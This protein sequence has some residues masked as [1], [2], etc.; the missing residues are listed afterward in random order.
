MFP[1]Y[2]CVE[3]RK[4]LRG[5]G[6]RGGLHPIL[7][8]QCSQATQHLTGGVLVPQPL[9]ADGY[10]IRVKVCIMRLKIAFLFMLTW[11]S[12]CD[13]D[14]VHPDITALVDWVVKYQFTYLPIRDA[15]EQTCWVLFSWT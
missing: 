4:E 8:L 12:N 13:H 11:V 5:G 7:V 1:P 15:D 10:F 9:P 3:G 6:G 2:F 14:T